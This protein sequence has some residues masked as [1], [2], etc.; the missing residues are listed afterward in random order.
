[1][2]NPVVHFEINGSDGAALQRFYREAFEWQI[3][4]DSEMSYGAVEPEHDGIGGVIGSGDTS[5]TL[6]IEVADLAA[7]LE[8]IQHLGGTVVQGITGGADMAPMALFADPEGNIVGLLE[9]ER[10]DQP[11]GRGAQEHTAPVSALP[12]WSRFSSG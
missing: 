11:A 1:V 3:Q 2:P 7:A 4:S 6:Y 12:P 5:V 8:R 9:A 10:P